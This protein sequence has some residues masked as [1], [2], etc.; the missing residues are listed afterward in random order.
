MKKP[1]LKKKAP[2]SEEMTLQITSMADIFTILLVFLLKSY[3]TGAISITPS[4]GMLLPS[5]QAGEASEEALKVQVSEQSVNVEGRPVSALHDFEFDRSDLQANGSSASL[6]RAIERERQ[7]E[8]LIAKA[9][10]DVKVDARIIVVADRRVPY[11][12]LKTVL[13]SA[14][15]GG[16]TDFKLA[17]I[18]R[19]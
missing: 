9:N 15:L 1:F 5:A 7:R 2:P 11:S 13:A 14:A 8:L 12:T 4:A 6:S 19:E 16:Y 10:A 3:A 18:N 17:V